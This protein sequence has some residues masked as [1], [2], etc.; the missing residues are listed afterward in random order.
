MPDVVR[1]FGPDYRTSRYAKESWP[2]DFALTEGIRNTTLSVRGG[3]KLS[4]RNISLIIIVHSD[5]HFFI[6]L[7]RQE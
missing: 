3:T 4:G 7:S 6:S 1:E 2:D 5:C